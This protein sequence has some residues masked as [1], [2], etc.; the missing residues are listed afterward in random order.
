[1][2]AVAFLPWTVIRNTNVR[3][4]KPTILPVEIPAVVI[5]PEQGKVSREGSQSNTDADQENSHP[6]L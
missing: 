5:K 2:I 6:A 4:R 3:I 1:M